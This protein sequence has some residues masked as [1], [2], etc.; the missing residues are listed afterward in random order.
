MDAI[1]GLDQPLPPPSNRDFADEADTPDPVSDLSGKDCL[2]A[3]EKARD[4][5]AP[6]DVFQAVTSQRR[7]VPFD[8]PP[9]S[10][11]NALRRT[12]ASPFMLRFDCGDFQVTGASPEILACAFGGEVT[13]RRS[14]APGRAE[15][16]RTRT[17]R[18]KPSP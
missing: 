8:L 15:R 5:I 18:R 6:G 4:C 10:L 2:A 12:S 17:V 11:C 13:F 9:F 16:P 7:T 3:V 14:P 1:R